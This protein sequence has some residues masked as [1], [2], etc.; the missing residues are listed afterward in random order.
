MDDV[1]N[2]HHDLIAL[3]EIWATKWWPNQQFTFLLLVAE[4]KNAVQ[5]WARARKEAAEPTLNFHKQLVKFMLT[6]KSR[7]NGVVVP[8]LIVARLKKNTEHEHK[9]KSVNQGKWNPSKKCF[10]AVKME[11]LCEKCSNC[12]A[13]TREYCTS[14]PG[15]PLCR[16]CFALH[17]EEHGS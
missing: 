15:C 16:G 6:N 13:T 12:T 11:Y 5:V 10:N 9:C 8:S 4:A 2:Q 17:L 14:N 1:N 3:E 7:D